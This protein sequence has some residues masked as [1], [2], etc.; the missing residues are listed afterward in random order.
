MPFSDGGVGITDVVPHPRGA[1][2][3]KVDEVREL[4]DDTDVEASTASC[5]DGVDNDSSGEY[6]CQVESCRRFVRACCQ[7]LPSADCCERL[8]PEV[9]LLTLAST[10][11]VGPASVCLATR[12]STFGD[13]P[14]VIGAGGALLPTGGFL[15]E[16]GVVLT[17]VE[18]DPAGLSLSF[19]TRVPSAGVCM[20]SCI[21]FVGVGVVDL[22]ALS[23]S[24]VRPAAGVV[25][26]AGRREVQLV[27]DGAVAAR[28]PLP[29]DDG[30]RFVEVTLSLE[31]LPGGELRLFIGDGEALRAR[32]QRAPNP[33]RASLVVWGRSSVSDETARAAL[34]T[35]RLIRRRCEAPGTW[36]A[37][38][39]PIG[40]F[41]GEPID[42]DVLRDGDLLRYAYVSGD[43]VLVATRAA[44]EAPGDVGDTAVLLA[45]VAGRRWGGPD[46]ARRADGGYILHVADELSGCILRATGA[47][48]RDL[49]LDDQPVVCPSVAGEP[50][51]GSYEAFRDPS[52]LLR[53]G[54]MTADVLFVRAVGE[55][56]RAALLALPLDAD[57][58]YPGPVVE[59]PRIVVRRPTGIVADLDAD[60]LAAPDVAWIDGAAQL[61]Y[62]GRTGSR[63]SVGLLVSSKPSGFRDLRV[64]FALADLWSPVLDAALQPS[65]RP[66]QPDA[67]G[68]YAPTVTASDGQVDLLHFASDGTRS[69]IVHRRRPT[70]TTFAYEL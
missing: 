62:A 32:V 17:A 28:A 57:G 69:T 34:L 53:A 29:A 37:V 70:T 58:R 49:V 36:T 54:R 64:S 63:W 31:W 42:V 41:R 5:L 68:V 16:S 59:S 50:G 47:E 30:A 38:Q 20:G 44:G 26:S 35:A 19:K 1:E 12:Q 56:A 15:S 43:A 33:A 27:A 2:G 11:C 51:A 46:L 65:S 40:G 60:D 8:T 24:S 25:V 61:W 39:S 14:P 13:P 6:D 48:A 22:E 3:F 7:R 10:D 18:D 21:D 45:P 55:E 23:A 4:E 9:D 52:L 66:G 67:F